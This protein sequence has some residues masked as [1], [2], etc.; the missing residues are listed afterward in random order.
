MK[1]FIEYTGDRDNYKYPVN[2]LDVAEILDVNL[3][4]MTEGCNIYIKGLEGYNG[5]FTAE[6]GH[7][8]D[9]RNQGFI[10][11]EHDKVNLYD[12]LVD[13]VKKIK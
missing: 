6:T 10:C 4:C 8:C 5:A 2:R 9:L 13:E 1:D 12:E 7:T 11:T 3:Y